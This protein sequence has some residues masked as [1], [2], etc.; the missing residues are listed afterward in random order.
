[1][2]FIRFRLGD[3]MEPEKVCEELMTNCL[4]PDCQMG[5]LGCDNMTVMSKYTFK[6]KPSINRSIIKLTDNMIVL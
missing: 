3:R 2:N 1:M 4:S 5:G 6:I